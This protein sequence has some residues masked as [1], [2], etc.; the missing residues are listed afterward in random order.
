MSRFT[1]F[2]EKSLFKK[3]IKVLYRQSMNSDGI[4]LNFSKELDF[5]ASFGEIRFVLDMR[6]LRE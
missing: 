1:G 4:A 3:K 2:S 5:H 6:V